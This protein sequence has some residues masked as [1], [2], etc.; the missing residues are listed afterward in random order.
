MTATKIDVM[1]IINLSDKHIRLAIDVLHED[2][3]YNENLGNFELCAELR[4]LQKELGHYL[5]GYIDL[6]DRIKQIIFYAYFEYG[7]VLNVLE[8]DDFVYEATYDLEGLN[9]TI[10][11]D[12][13]KNTK[14]I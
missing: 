10:I 12:L 11:F 4:D 2:M 14:G 5:L 9:L 8:D 7:S 13:K 1:E 3:K 6:T